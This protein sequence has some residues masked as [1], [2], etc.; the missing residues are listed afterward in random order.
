MTQ[1]STF[2][3][4]YK[5]NV[6]DFTLQEARWYIIDIING[7][8]SRINKKIIDYFSPNNVKDF[9]SILLHTSILNT[10]SKIKL[11]YSLKLINKSTQN[12]LREIFS[13]RDAF[14][15]MRVLTQAN[16]VFGQDNQMENIE[17]ITDVITIMTSSWEIKEKI[18]K[19][20]LEEFY[21]RNIE[22]N[23]LL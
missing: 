10:W 5:Q 14:I 11:L 17:S 18:A 6:N 12:K 7:I 2:S 13:I 19:E 1:R 8:D 20:Y 4:S 22:L 21:Q 9:E 3:R 15:H 16:I 23:N